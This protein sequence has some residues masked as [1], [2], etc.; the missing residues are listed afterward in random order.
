MDLALL[1]HGNACRVF[2]D[3]L[4]TVAKSFLFFSFGG[5]CRIGHGEHLMGVNCNEGICT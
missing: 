5:G 3:L 2:C 1:M 4:A